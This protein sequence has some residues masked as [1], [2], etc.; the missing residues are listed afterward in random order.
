ML[1]ALA[2][3]N[4]NRR[5]MG[6]NYFQRIDSGEILNPVYTPFYTIDLEEALGEQF[7]DENRGNADQQCN[8]DRC[9]Q[10]DRE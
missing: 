9:E 1:H 10:A 5:K 4:G 7:E 8:M 6:E 3:D 2:S